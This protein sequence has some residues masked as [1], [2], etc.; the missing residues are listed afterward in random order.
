[1]RLWL[2]LC[3]ILFGVI[4][5]DQP[6]AIGC[7]PLT[8]ITTTSIP[9]EAVEHAYTSATTP[10][11]STA[12]GSPS[13]TMFYVAANG[14]DSHPCT[15]SS[16]CATPDYAFN[17]LAQPGDTVQ[18]AAGVYSYTSEVHFRSSGSSGHYITLTCATRGA[19]T[20][21]NNVT[22]NSTVIETDGEYQAIRGFVFT[23]TSSGNNLGIY[24][25]GSYQNISENTIH[26]IAVNCSY[27]GGGIQLADSASNIRMDANL[28]YDIAMRNGI[29]ACPAD[30]NHTDGIIA[31]SAGANIV[32]TNNI[33]YRTSGG[34]GILLGPGNG[35]GGNVPTDQ[36]SNNLIFSTARGGIVLLVG[37][38]YVANNILIDN[39]TQTN[40][41]AFQNASGLPEIY[42]NNDLFNNRGGNYCLNYNTASGRVHSGDIAVNPASGTTFVNWQADGSGDYHERA[43]SPTIGAGSSEGAPPTHDYDGNQRAVALDMGPYQYH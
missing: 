14:S 16:P 30:A 4:A 39:G 33:I 10:A 11:A 35:G 37:G 8:A 26:G 31:E 13:G 28:I 36:I 1:M 5:L 32:I 27:G 17:N 7:D 25:T 20:I 3:V 41:C 19:C 9:A 22:G 15:E 42:R 34:W 29:P 43:G 18:V 21:E 6:I 38:V 40:A 2:E 23:N 24:V 12:P